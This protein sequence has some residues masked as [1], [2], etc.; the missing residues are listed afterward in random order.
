MKPTISPLTQ[1]PAWKALQAHYPQMSKRHL[2][3]LF[4][5]DTNRGERLVVDAIGVYFDY[6]KYRVTDETIDL[7]VQLAE[8][9][10]LRDRIE[11][12]FRGDKNNQTERNVRSCT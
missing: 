11:A 4:A 1:L 6:A 8:E 12:M 2:R 10:G 7:L 5:E 9:S 3:D